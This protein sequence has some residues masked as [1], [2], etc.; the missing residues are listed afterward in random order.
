MIPHVP[1][2][3]GGVSTAVLLTVLGFMGNGIVSN[4]VRN[5]EAHTKIT[6]GYHTEDVRVLEKVEKVK[7]IVTNIRIEQTQMYSDIRLEQH[8]QKVLLQSIA[9]KL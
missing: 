3:I 4:D 9:G 1:K 5:T 6:N 2:I 7:D 8:E